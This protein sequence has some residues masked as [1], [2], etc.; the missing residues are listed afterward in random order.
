MSATLLVRTL[1]AASA[2]ALEDLVDRERAR[3]WVPRDLPHQLFR[4]GRPEDG[5]HAWIVIM[6]RKS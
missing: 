5:P 2:G 1:T 4:R 6:E 3:R